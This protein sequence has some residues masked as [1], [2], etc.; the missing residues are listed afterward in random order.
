MTVATLNHTAKTVPP[1][2]YGDYLRFGKLVQDRCGLYFPDRRRTE[3]ELGVRQAFAT[4]TCTD[5]NDY[6]RL[7]QDPDNGALEMDRLINALTISE[8][9]FFRDA[10]QCDALYS[11]VLPQII[12]RRSALRT[13]RIWSAGCASGEEPYTIA[14]ML[15]ELLPNVD[16][17]TITILGTDINTETLDRARKAVYSDWAF[18]E[19]RAK[20]WRLRYFRSQGNRYELIPEVQRMVTF[21]RLNLAEDDYPSFE[22]NTTLMDLVLCRNV[23][24]YF[25]ESVIR[26][27][28]ERF[29]DALVDGGWLVVGHSEISL[30]T[31]RRF[32]ARNFPNAILYQRTG[33]PTILP[34]D[35]DWLT[36]PSQEGKNSEIFGGLGDL[37]IPVPA[38]VDVQPTTPAGTGRGALSSRHPEPAL[39]RACRGVEGSKGCARTPG[40]DHSL[41]RAQELLDYG[42]SEEARDLLLKLTSLEPDHPSTGAGHC[43]PACALLGRAYANLGCWSEAEH[44]CRQALRFDQLALDAYYT[45]ALVLQHRG[46]LDQ[47]IK[48]MKKVIYIDRNYVLGHFG[49]ANLYRISGQLSQA[50]KSLDNAHHLLKMRAAEEVIPG[51]GGITAGRLREATIRQQQ[52]WNAKREAQTKES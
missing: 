45:L 15:R 11:H 48:A 2:G 18:R 24:I 16:E 46:Q 29:Y 41:E 36:A 14:M 23:T 1:L 40:D 7:L 33:Q 30:T 27:V 37:D 51:S 13:M 10:G 5:L 26:K 25:T 20:Q 6:Y 47:A 44:W 8:S 35:W 32:Q 31:Y 21:A 34:P 22:T 9:H 19:E 43:A 12:K 52:Q 49:L 38:P 39:S 3:L 50:Q 4:S 28:V 17:W 42:R